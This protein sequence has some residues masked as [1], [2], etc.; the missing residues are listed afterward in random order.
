MIQYCAKEPFWV[1]VGPSSAPTV[2]YKKH[3]LSIAQY[4][5]LTFYKSIVFLLSSLVKGKCNDRV[6]IIEEKNLIAKCKLSIRNP[7]H[8][9]VIKLFLFL[10]LTY[11][12]SLLVIAGDTLTREGVRGLYKGIV[13]TKP[14]VFILS[15][16]TK[17]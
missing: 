16:F 2:V 17:Q 15:C 4:R 6:Q 7:Q 13:Q 9:L 8:S 10:S 12:Y 3:V 5:Y 11:F 14:P 1:V